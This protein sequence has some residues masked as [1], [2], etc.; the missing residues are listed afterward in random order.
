MINLKDEPP[1]I[2]MA[3]SAMGMSFC[4]CV[5]QDRETS[6]CETLSCLKP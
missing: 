3:A 5:C 4:P 2:M 6:A 1:F